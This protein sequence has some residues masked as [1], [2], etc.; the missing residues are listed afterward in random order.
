M[1]GPLLYILY[2]SEMVALVQ[3]RLYVYPDDSTLLTVVRKTADRPDVTASLNKDL[4]Q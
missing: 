4:A 3:N 1:F 2:I